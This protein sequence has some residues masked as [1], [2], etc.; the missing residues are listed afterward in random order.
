MST[1]NIFASSADFNN[2][3][4]LIEKIE[5]ENLYKGRKSALL[6]AVNQNKRTANQL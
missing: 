6:L 5:E 1:H 3:D 4:Y 2:P